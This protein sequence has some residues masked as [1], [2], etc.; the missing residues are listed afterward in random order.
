VARG[1][2]FLAATK[3]AA[4]RGTSAGL[5]LAAS[6]ACAAYAAY[7]A[8]EGM[9][10]VSSQERRSEGGDAT[11]D[12]EDAEDVTFSDVICGQEDVAD[13]VVLP[14]PVLLVETVEGVEEETEREGCRWTATAEAAASLVD[15]ITDL[16]GRGKSTLT[17]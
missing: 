10:C 14:A 15:K 8:V 16:A 3:E 2:R 5:E 1:H 12:E 9:E 17:K 11:S 6:W 13:V 7:A 4:T